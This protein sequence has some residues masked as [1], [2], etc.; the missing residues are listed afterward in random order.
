MEFKNKREHVLY[1]FEQGNLTREQI[2][3]QAGVTAKSFGSICSTLR[4]MGKYPSKKEDGTY[5]LISKDEYEALM[6]EK[7]EKAPKETL[8][9]E[10]LERAQKAESKAAS[11]LTNRK[12]KFE[13]D[14]SRENELA[15]KIA[16]MELELASIRLSKLET[17]DLQMQVEEQTTS[18][19][20]DEQPW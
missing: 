1:L 11:A 17:A 3:E 8:T 16:E 10:R 5:N 20:T 19:V 12:E 4:L 2:I 18:P 6:A 7:A 14:P 9:P 15:F 13:K